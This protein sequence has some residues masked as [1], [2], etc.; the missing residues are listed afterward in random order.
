MYPPS[1]F[2]EITGSAGTT[3]A[4]GSAAFLVGVER[5]GTLVGVDLNRDAPLFANC[6]CGA[7]QDCAPLLDALLNLTEKEDPH[8]M[9]KL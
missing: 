7:V 5:S 4:S 8:A 9:G 1:I 6:D 3:G 2:A